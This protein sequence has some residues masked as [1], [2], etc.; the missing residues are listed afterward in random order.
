MKLK[1]YFD[2]NPSVVFSENLKL[3]NESDIYITHNNFGICD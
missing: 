2:K 1:D 3:Q